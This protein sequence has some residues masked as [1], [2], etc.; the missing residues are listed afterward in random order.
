MI[1][2]AEIGV[3]HNGKLH[4]A[5]KLIKNVK[6]L[7][8]DYVKFQIYK[9][10][11]FV[12]KK[13]ISARYQK[14]VDNSQFK[15]L[16]NYEIEFKKYISLFK[17]CKKLK[18]K[19]LVTCFDTKTFDKIDNFLKAK[20]YK[21]SSGDLDNLPFLYHIASKQ[22]KIIISTG[23]ANQKEID[24]ALKTLIYAYK[25]KKNPNIKKIKNV[26]LSKSNLKI[27]KD[28]VTI[29]HCISEYPVKVENLNLNFIVELKKKYNLNI[30]FSDH[31]KS[32]I[33]AS[34]AYLLGATYFEK[35]ITLSNF[36]K[37]PDH[38]ASLNYK[39]FKIMMSNLIETK[40]MLGKKKK[41]VNKNELKNKT[42][43]RRSLVAKNKIF[44]NE[45]FSNDNL[46]MKRPQIGK[47]PYF[48]WNYI[49]KKSKKM[50]KMD[51][52]I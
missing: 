50:Y 8:A 11:E 32:L 7:G 42:I 46:A 12:T 35:H 3:N 47:K 28:K 24:L 23:M 33:S 44:K 14:K 43:V 39:D 1:I 15:L 38:N 41:I 5:K 16:Q 20:L 26:K 29:L 13:S 37:G 10:N 17:Y 36:Y 27:L 45:L 34:V 4:L 40:K 9:T 2:I 6:K 21:I 31:S 30:G 19:S 18:I 49:G 51:D 52:I 22:K 48:L 25:N